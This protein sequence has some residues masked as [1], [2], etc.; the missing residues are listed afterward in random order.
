MT[1][2]WYSVE[3]GW[4][5]AVRAIKKALQQAGSEPEQ[6]PRRSISL[7]RGPTPGAGFGFPFPR[8]PAYAKIP[9]R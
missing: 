7:E 4:R 5:R 9:P 8:V 6:K 2:N 3:S 1:F